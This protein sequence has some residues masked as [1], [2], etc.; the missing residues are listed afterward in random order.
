MAKLSIDDVDVN[1]KSVLMRVDFNVP[2]DADLRITDDRRIEMALPSIRSVISRGGRLVLMS[3][4]GRPAGKGF[5]AE[6]SLKPVADRLAEKVGQPVGYASDTVGEDATSRFAALETG[7]ILLLK[8]CGSTKG[9]KQATF[10]LP[11]SWQ[12]LAKFTATM[13]LELAIEKTHPWWLFLKPW[14]VNPVV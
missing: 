2:L 8:T 12:V 6:F 10:N 1:G 7:Q 11:N 9:R 3:H 14:S 4:L 5:E 13:H